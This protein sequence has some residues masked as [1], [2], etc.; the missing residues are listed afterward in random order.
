[1]V[2][3]VTLDSTAVE[4]E[5]V[6]ENPMA[7]EKDGFIIKVDTSGDQPV[8][9]RCTLLSLPLSKGVVC[10]TRDPDELI[11]LLSETPMWQRSR[12]CLDQLGCG[13]CL[14][15]KRVGLDHDWQYTEQETDADSGGAHG[16]HR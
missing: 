7:L 16:D 8:G 3:R 14:P 13:R 11:H 2:Q 1:M 5:I 6:L 12:L 4:E 9:R 10:D 15:C